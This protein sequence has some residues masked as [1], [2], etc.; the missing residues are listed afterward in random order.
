MRWGGG[1]PEQ[2]LNPLYNTPHTDKVFQCYNEYRKAQQDLTSTAHK[3]R[4]H[5]AG[6]VDR[7]VS[8]GTTE[9]A[10]LLVDLALQ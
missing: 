5:C 6:P 1:H 10:P 3:G 2:W 4:H 8:M 9:A 7:C